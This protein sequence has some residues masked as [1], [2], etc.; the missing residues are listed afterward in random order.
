MSFATETPSVCVQQPL[1][2]LLWTSALEQ[3]K[4]VTVRRT[5]NPLTPFPL[6]PDDDAK[7]KAQL[8]L[9]NKSL[10][11][12]LEEVKTT[13]SQT[14][15]TLKATEEQR[16]IYHEHLE[17]TCRTLMESVKGLMAVTKNVTTQI[18]LTSG[19]GW[20]M[21]NMNRLVLFPPQGQEDF[22]EEVHAAAPVSQDNGADD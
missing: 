9:A 15:K 21:V 18:D 20:K 6:I 12:E 1:V 14:E 8:D 7:V 16:T 19:R 13:L 5:V 22:R 4:H 2:G 11:Q 3:S 10:S 17:K